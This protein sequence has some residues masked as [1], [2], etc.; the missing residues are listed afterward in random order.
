MKSTTSTRKTTRPRSARSLT[1]LPQL[2][3]IWSWEM[4]SA[5]TPTVS[6]MPG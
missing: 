2:A 1:S 6:M 3:P 5:V 4:S